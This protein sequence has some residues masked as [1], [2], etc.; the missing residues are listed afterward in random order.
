LFYE[1]ELLGTIRILQDHSIKGKEF[2]YPSSRL[3]KKRL[4]AGSL[5]YEGK[6]GGEV[7][8]KCSFRFVN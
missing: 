6:E 4:L 1:I 2:N 8:D 7:K 3:P 5:I